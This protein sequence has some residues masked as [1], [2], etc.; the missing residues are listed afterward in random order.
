MKTKEELKAE[1]HKII[2]AID[3]EPTLNIFMDDFTAYTIN[4]KNSI[5]SVSDFTEEQYA[6]IKK[7]LESDY[8]KNNDYTTS[9]IIDNNLSHFQNF[10]LQKAIDEAD[11]GET[12]TWNEYL[13]STAKWR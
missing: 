4:L 5:I 6:G 10:Q 11:N 9:P 13:N 8:D 7:V 12:L 1:L 2:D 3:D